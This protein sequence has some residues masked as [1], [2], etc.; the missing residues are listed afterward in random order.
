MSAHT[1]AASVM[2]NSQLTTIKNVDVE[3][4]TDKKNQRGMLQMKIEEMQRKVNNVFKQHVTRWREMRIGTSKL[5]DKIN[6]DID[7]TK[8]AAS[9]K[10]MMEKLEKLEKAK[11]TKSQLSKNTNSSSKTSLKS[12]RSNYVT[13]R[14]NVRVGVFEGSRVSL[15][16]LH[17]K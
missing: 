17:H 5:L 15:S 6:Q 13:N 2:T 9:T 7:K 4:Q 11:R 8:T 16:S 14:D 3:M 10:A 1:K 12:K